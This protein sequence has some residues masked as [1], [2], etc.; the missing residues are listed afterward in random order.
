[1]K[2]A[3]ELMKKRTIE[4]PMF[5]D[6][7]IIARLFLLLCQFDAAIT[8][9]QPYTQAAAFAVILTRYADVILTQAAALVRSEKDKAAA[10][11]LWPVTAKSLE[12]AYSLARNRSGNP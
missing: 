2:D 9:L 8:Q 3:A 7:E 6:V 1:M 5:A 4:D 11:L 10:D 12:L